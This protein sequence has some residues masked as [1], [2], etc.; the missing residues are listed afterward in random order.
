MRIYWEKEP[1]IEQNLDFQVLKYNFDKILG[2]TFFDSVDKVSLWRS[3]QTM[4][5]IIKVK[6]V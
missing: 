4:V 1:N 5:N 2:L 6:F 3:S